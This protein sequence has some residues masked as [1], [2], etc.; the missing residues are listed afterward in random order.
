MHA[1]TGRPTIIFDFDGT[2][3]NT[4]EL[5]VKI[6]NRIAPEYGCRTVGDDI[7]ETLRHG[8]PQDLMKTFGVTIARLPRFVLRMRK[9][10]GRCMSE[11]A[12]VTGMPEAVRELAAEPFDLGILSSN[13]VENVEAFLTANGL[14][15][16]FGFIRS[17]IHLFGK[18]VVLRKLM[19]A[20]HIAP[21]R[22]MY[23][24]DETR[25]IEAAK[26][27]GIPVVAVSWGY[28]AGDVLLAASPDALADH[29]G[30]LVKCI[31]RIARG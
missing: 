22:A 3:A 13:G 30:E 21:D 24:G 17:G 20:R 12:P 6:Y 19:R 18:D 25:D 27:T 29:P 28:Q 7:R 10:I 23:I 4:L 15:R 5:V 9:E 11:V 26:K 16:Y 1:A 31:R 14:D 8:R 2:I